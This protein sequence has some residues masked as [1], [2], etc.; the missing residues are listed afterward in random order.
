M[1]NLF[2]SFIFSIN[3]TLPIIILLCLGMILGKR[4]IL[5][6]AFSEKAMKLIFNLTLPLLLFFNIYNGKIEYSNQFDLIFIAILGTTILFLIGELIAAKFIDEKRERCTFVQA[7]FRGNNAVLGLA[8]C[9]NAYGNQ[10]YVPA[11]IYS[12][13][14]V[15]L[16]N[17]FG[18][19]TIT[20]SLSTDKVQI[21]TL[22]LR[23][24]QNPLIIAI[25]L[26]LTMNYFAVSLFKPLQTTGQYLANIT[27]PL[28]VLCTGASID[29]RYMKAS[30]RTVTWGVISR[31]VIAPLFMVTLAKLVGVSGMEL[32]IIF[33][34]TTTPLATAAYAM[35]RAMGGNATT[36]ANIIG[37]TTVG[38]MP[39]SSLGLMVLMQ[40]GWI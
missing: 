36:V 21:G 5:D 33:L 34:M 38:A 23:I 4:R 9:I 27:L 13:I 16:Y 28:A 32:A 20:R 6:D 35:V 24:I 26:G 14:I 31:L 18:V 2:S 25:I 40:L 7:L 19:I 30:S 10:A 39:L 17:V 37:I 15:I 29:F 11:S 12:A 3:A 1:T 22:F 8:L